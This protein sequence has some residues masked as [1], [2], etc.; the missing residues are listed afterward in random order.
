MSAVDERA[1]LADSRLKVLMVV[2]RSDPGGTE[3]AFGRILGQLS[4][5]QDL[6]LT[7]AFPT[8]GA[9]AGSWEALAP[10]LDYEAGHLPV[11]WYPKSYAGWAYRRARFASAFKKAVAA[12]RPAV[13]VSFTSVLTVPVEVC[14]QLGIPCIAYVREYV[15]PRFVRERLWR[16]LGAKADRLIAVSTP[17][18]AD[19]EPYAPSRVRL[20]SDGVPLPREMHAQQWPPE[21]PFVAFY[22]GY[23]PDKGGELFV[24][25]AALVRHRI[26]AA[27]F[28][29]YG[30]PWPVQQSY[31]GSVR[32]LAS[33]LG[34][35][36]SID[37]AQTRE[38]AGT[39]GDA[40]LVVMPSVREGLGLVAIEA[41][42]YGVPVVAT[43]V[44][45]L[46]D[47][48]DDGVTG[49]LVAPGDADAFAAAA[50]GLLA[51]TARLREAGAQARLRVEGRFGIE[52]AASGLKKTILEVAEGAKR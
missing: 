18:A 27:R 31:A 11:T 43:R 37:F 51:D 33:R 25:I 29:F 22:G 38:Y 44:G 32:E 15:E 41:M 47:V 42:S 28:V 24:R 46:T 40:S 19:L 6:D 50:V 10:H 1:G 7:I 34:L 21:P 30:V 16:Y 20:V 9:L 39:F 8:G 52:Q 14:H 35:D 2:H 23:E 12:R 3:A 17:L 49:A 45:G 13:V 5:A 36:G 48:V 4:A 26:P